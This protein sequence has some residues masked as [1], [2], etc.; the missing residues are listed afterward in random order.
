MVMVDK[1]KIGLDIDGVI[2]NFVDTFVDVVKE[3]YGVRFS[4]DD[5]REHDLYE[6]L[7]IS[8]ADALRLI[9]A[10]LM[11]DL[12]PQAGA[13]DAIKQLSKSHQLYFIT[14][15]PPDT[16]EITKCWLQKHGLLTENLIFLK[17]G[18]K[19]THTEC[20]DVVIDDNLDEIIGWLGKTPLIIVFDHPWNKSVNIKKNFVPAYGWH[21]ILEILNS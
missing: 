19:F 18:T 8:K 21:D 20:L 4:Q 9:R 14:A 12:E 16:Y 3:E 10:T 7:G 6:V 2:T 17:D 13:I 1:M 5:V 15:R 11:R